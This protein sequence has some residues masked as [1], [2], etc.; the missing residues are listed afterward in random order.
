MTKHLETP[1][2][3]LTPGT[4]SENL[5]YGP[6]ARYWWSSRSTNNDIE[7]VFFPIRLGQK[8]RVFRNNREFIVLV[9]LGNPEHSMQPGYFCSSGSFSGQ[10]ESSPTKAISTLYKE[11]FHNS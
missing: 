2:T 6:Y 8:T 3:L 4:I 1:V 5:H 11:I 10:I 7:N 9:V